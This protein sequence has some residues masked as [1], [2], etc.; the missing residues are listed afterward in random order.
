MPK[1]DM[2]KC[3]VGGMDR[4]GRIILGIVLLLVA[5][6]VPTLGTSLK[7][8]LFVIA[9]IALVTAVIR[10]CPANALLGLNSCKMG[11]NPG[12]QAMGK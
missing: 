12:S 8:L 7:I 4:I 5:L 6:L 9:A 10:F 11:K 3:N 1:E 2:M